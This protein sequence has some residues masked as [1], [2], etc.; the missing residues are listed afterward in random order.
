M[1]DR[2]TPSTANDP[3]R[4]RRNSQ[5][6]AVERQEFVQRLEKLEKANGKV[7]VKRAIEPLRDLSNKKVVSTNRVIQEVPD[8][9]VAYSQSEINDDILPP[10]RQALQTLAQKY[11]ELAERLNEVT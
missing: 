4:T 10:I 6:A 11:N 2:W 1:P 7:R 9:G 8:A 5:L 3:T